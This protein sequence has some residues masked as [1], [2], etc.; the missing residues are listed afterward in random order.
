MGTVTGS[1]VYFKDSTAIIE[2]IP[3]Q[4]YRFVKW[5]D[6]ITDN[7]RTITVTSDTNITAIFDIIDAITEITTSPIAIYPNPARDHISIIL[8]ENVLNAVF[9][10]YDMQGKVLLQQNIG[11]QDVVSVNNLAAGIYI[12]SVRTDK[13]NYQGKIIRK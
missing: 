8:P 3:N 5:D 10:L 4:G 11:N 7:P 1:G 9:T 6:N 13:V 12:Y 2:A